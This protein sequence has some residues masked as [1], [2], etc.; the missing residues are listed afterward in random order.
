M[1]D[2]DMGEQFLN[3]PLH[4]S[5]QPFCSVDL[6]PYYDP[7]NTRKQNLVRRLGT[8][9]DGLQGFSLYCVKECSF[10]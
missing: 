7:F 6:R 3:F 4:P 10:S 5:I 2:I 1:A 8:V 9:Y